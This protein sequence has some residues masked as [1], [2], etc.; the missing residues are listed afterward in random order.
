MEVGIGLPSTIPG[1]GRHQV[2][3]W[4][5]RAEARG[6]STLGTIDRIVYPSHEP[7]IAL[8]AA[9]A[10]TE[11]IRLATTILLAP[12]RANG[13]LLAKQA[14][15]LDVLS[16]GRLVL[17]VAVGRR[18]DDFRASGVDF[19]A[20]GRILDEMLDLWARI[21]DGE[22]F[23]TAGGIGPRPANG[24]PALIVGGFASAAFTR[25]ARHGDGWSAGNCTLEELAQGTARLG[26]AW[27]AAG[28]DGSPRTLVQPYYALGNRAKQAVE[29]CLGDYYG[30]EGAET[31]T[32]VARA[33]TDVQ[34]VRENV[35]AFAQAGC[36]E[37]IFFPCDP[38]PDQVDLLADALAT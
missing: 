9:A 24:R 1:V 36:D 23:G 31:D 38:H 17:G 10:V 18:E 15:T 35:E 19:H 33:A 5:R 26:A 20:R 14:A 16:E 27:E 8:A 6:F 22:E 29:S 3:E 25:A 13:A 34:A 12:A 32:I 7:L 11:R 30:S 28:R 37:L 4:A 2:L 21:W